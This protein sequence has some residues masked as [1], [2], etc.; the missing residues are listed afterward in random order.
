[1]LFYN[2]HVFTA[3]PNAPYAEALIALATG[4]SKVLGN[5]ASGGTNR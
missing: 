5:S 4:D 1:M 3:E 2:A